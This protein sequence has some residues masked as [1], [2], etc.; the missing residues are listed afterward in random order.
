MA[1]HVNK[2]LLRVLTILFFLSISVGCQLSKDE[3]VP[4]DFVGH[5]VTDVPR[6]ENCYLDITETTISFLTATGELNTFFI[7]RVERTVIEK[8]NVLVFHYENRDG[9][10]F[11]KPMV[12]IGTG[13]DAQI[14]FLNQKYLKWRKVNQEA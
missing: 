2:H 11:L 12:Q 9:V 3:S 14:Q 8:Q 1:I 13:D 4:P 7:N 6:Y 10:E 5:W